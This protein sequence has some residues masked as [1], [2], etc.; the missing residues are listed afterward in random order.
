MARVKMWMDF[1]MVTGA[2]AMPMRVYP[3]TL[4]RFTDFVFRWKGVG[5]PANWDWCI[6]CGSEMN[7][8]LLVAKQAVRE[9]LLKLPKEGPR[10]FEFVLTKSGKQRAARVAEA[11]LRDRLKSV[12]AL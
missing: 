7:N 10:G 5:P 9:G 4:D 3:K 6:F 12:Q 2:I 11:V 1:V 8:G